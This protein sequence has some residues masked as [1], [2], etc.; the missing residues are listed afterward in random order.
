MIHPPLSSVEQELVGS[1]MTVREFPA[2]R[3]VSLDFVFNS[4]R[5]L[6]HKWT[7]QKIVDGQTVVT[8]DGGVDPG[9][10]KV[11]GDLLTIKPDRS[12]QRTLYIQFIRLLNRMTGNRFVDG[13]QANARIRFLDG[14]TLQVDWYDPLTDKTTLTEN[15]HRKSAEVET[16]NNKQ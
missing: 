7:E 10:W 9:H 5:E 6:L 13:E 2:G 12:G 1:W 11:T 15:F 16:E 3:S 8:T 14:D 4:K